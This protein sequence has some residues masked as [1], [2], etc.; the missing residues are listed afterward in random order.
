LLKAD[1]RE[2]PASL[3][4]EAIQERKISRNHGELVSR[5][6]NPK[7]DQ[8]HARTYFDRLQVFPEA[9]VNLQE[10]A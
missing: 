3:Q 5:H 4:R 7:S 10:L 8:E 6:Q 1:G 2:L 9:S